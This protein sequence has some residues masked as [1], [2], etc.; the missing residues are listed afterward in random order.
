[1]KKKE[2]SVFI[3]YKWEDEIRNQWVEKLYKDLRSAGIDAKL[4]TYEVAPGESFSDY[5]TREIRECNFV[6]FIVTP[7]AVEAVE[8]GE[9]ALAFEMQ[10]SNARRIARKDGFRI[11][12]IFRE[13]DKTS[14]YLS[15]H[16][17][18]DFRD[19]EKYNMTLQYLL[20]WLHGSVEPPVIGNGKV[21]IPKSRK[22]K[23]GM[24]DQLKKETNLLA[25]ELHKAQHDLKETQRIIRIKEIELD[26]VI[27]QAEDVSH[28]DF[29]TSLPNRRQ[30]IKILEN[31]VFRSERYGTPLTILLL[32]L[33]SFKQINDAEGHA[34]GDRIL[35]LIAEQLSSQVKQPNV[36]G[37]YGDDEFLVIM[38]NSMLKA[39]SEQ[40][41]LLCQ[42]IRSNPI[43][44]YKNEFQITTSIGI[45]E[46]RNKEENWQK[47]F[48]RAD[49][50]LYEA[51]RSGRDR[52]AISA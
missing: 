28:N 5:M 17:Y 39:G 36:I 14:S 13:G 15:D 20:D 29:L 48:Q 50:A 34:I 11:I 10:I 7:R 3:S 46:Y 22:N 45:A 16:R 41:Y 43:K 31:E 8:S 51:K 23:K 47:L 26:A 40:A 4:D 12:P 44:I 25:N 42:Y 18:L 1:M 32:D 6:L 27:A 30:I 49:Q 9:G 19:D 2:I 38:P 21:N 35:F 52:W 33:D 24:Y 37:R